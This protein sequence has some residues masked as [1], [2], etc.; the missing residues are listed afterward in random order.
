MKCFILRNIM[1]VV[2]GTAFKLSFQG[3]VGYW[4]PRYV[5]DDV[6]NENALRIGL[7]LGHCVGLLE[8]DGYVQR[9][10]GS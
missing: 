2:I 9:T 8:A 10:I 1:Y 6:I 5:K 7:I 3:Q 4:Q